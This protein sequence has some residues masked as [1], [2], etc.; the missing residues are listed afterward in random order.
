MTKSKYFQIAFLLWC[1]ACLSISLHA[2]NI[3][4]LWNIWQDNTKP[5]TT[6]LNAVQRFIWDGYLYSKPDS[7]FYFAQLQYDFANSKSLKYDMCAARNTQ[8]ISHII[9]GNFPE[10]LKYLKKCLALNEELGDELGLA[11]T[12]NNIAIV[13]S[14]QGNDLKA[15]EYHQKSL[16][17]KEKQNDERGVAQSYTSI[18]VIHQNYGNYSKALDYLKKGLSIFE[19]LGYDPGITKSFQNLGNQYFYLK[20]YHKAL[21]YYK[22]CLKLN[23]ELGDA[24]GVAISLQSMASVFEAEE[25]MSEALEYYQ[26][27]LEINKELGSEQGIAGLLTNIGS[28]FLQLGQTRKALEYCRQGYGIAENIQSLKIKKQACYCLYDSYKNMG[29]GNDALTYLEQIQEIDDSLQKDETNQELQRMEFAKQ[30]LEDS[31]ATA[32]RERLVKEAHEDELQKRNQIRNWALTGG[33]FALLL[34]GGF[35][36]RWRF[37]RKS[38]DMIS[39]E[40]ERSENLLL[41][42]LPAEIA[43]ELKEKGR[44]EARDFEMVSILFTDFKGFTAASEKLSAQDLVSEI[45]TCFEAF[46]GIIEKFGIE[47]IKTIGDSYMAAGGLPVPSDDS[48][49]NTI[50]AALEMQEYI[51][52]RKIQLTTIEKTGFDMRIG[53]HTGPVVAGIV[54]VKKFQYD[55]WGDTVNTASRMESS[56]QVGKVNISQTTYEI[57][58]DDA[59]FTFE[60]RGK[61]TAKGKGEIEMYFV[62][63]V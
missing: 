15:L 57:L 18:G 20:N 12:L 35:Y 42:I 49:K 16:V 34:A 63:K 1:S 38:R 29:N 23:K 45:N 28:I 37:V 48:V 19:E 56:G 44:A 17:L 33:L 62:N 43:E 24:N 47:K 9:R 31:L 52:N 26:K 40:K 32:E 50:L 4:S 30:M 2:Q 5:D 41:N 10:A 46:D 60:S 3:D 55:I 39:K 36:S 22:K 13:Y 59:Q 14:Q 53:I 27:S 8:G 51:S 61:I 58:K 7:A 54:G 11:T 25:N 21:E 6:R